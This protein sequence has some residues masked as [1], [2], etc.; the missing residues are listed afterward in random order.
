M[1]SRELRRWMRMTVNEGT[2]HALHDADWPI[3]GKTGTAQVNVSGQAR[4]HQWFVG[5]APEWIGE[6]TSTAI[7]AQH[8]PK[9]AIAVVAENMQPSAKNKVLPVTKD[10]I[11]FLSKYEVEQA[12]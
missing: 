1:A 10:I 7:R 12:R 11:N 9:Y 4:V 2:A 6:T 8:G 3:A 5:Y